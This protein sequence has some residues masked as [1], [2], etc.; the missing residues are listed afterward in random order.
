MAAA[1]AAAVTA[2]VAVIVEPRSDAEVVWRTA[3][4]MRNV[5]AMLGPAWGM[6]VFH[7]KANCK[8]LKAHFTAEE[9]AR[10]SWTGLG[11]DNLASSQEYSSLLCSLWFWSRV[12]AETVLIFQEDALLCG[13]SLLAFLRFAY[14]GAPWQPTEAWVRGKPWLA[15]V[16]GNGGLSLRRR[17][18]SLSCLDAASRQRGQWEDVFFVEALQQMGHSI[19]PA[20]EATAF[21]V[22][23]VWHDAPCGMH[24][25]YNY[26]SASQLAHLLRGVERAYSR[27]ALAQEAELPSETLA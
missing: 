4:V 12:A 22:E 24:K 18:L 11:V 9:Q 8:L 5:A 3:Q 25:A 6:Q 7:G 21:A 20:C 27:L 23:S 13:P 16:G 17:S 1:A 26:L 2:R 15:G 14:V 10:V 19:A